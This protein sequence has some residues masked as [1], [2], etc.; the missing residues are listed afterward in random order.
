[1]NFLDLIKKHISTTIVIGVSV[2]AVAVAGI[3][4]VS[5]YAKYLAYERQYNEEAADLYNK[6]ARLPEEV[7][8]DNDY[9]T[10]DDNNEAVDASKSSYS[11]SVILN[12]RDCVVAPLS[13]TTAET[14]VTIDGTHLGEAISGLNRKGGAISFSIEADD[15]GLADIEIAMMTNWFDSAQTYFELEKITDYIKIQIN[16]LNVVAEAGLS[17]SREEFTSLIL[18]NANLV[19][20]V[21][22]LTITTSAYNDKDN[23]NNY[24]YVMP[25]IRNVTFLCES[26]IQEISVEE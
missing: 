22:V 1:M 11:N 18:K 8:V 3:T 26:P 5:D 24:L 7:I 17:D 13:A 9:I 14:Y 20:G 2:V 21:N 12:A 16:K 23:K 15:H 10:Y 19:E 4:V 6:F 25:D